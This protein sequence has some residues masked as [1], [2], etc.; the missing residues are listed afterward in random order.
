M[1]TNNEYIKI[2]SKL[3][4]QRP[5]KRTLEKRIETALHHVAIGLEED[6]RLLPI[7]IRLESDLTQVR[8][9]LAALERSKSYA[10]HVN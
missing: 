10:L 1:K 4:T 7:C 3:P 5:S 6:D 8:N 2:K 9:E